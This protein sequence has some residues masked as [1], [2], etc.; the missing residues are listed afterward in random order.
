[1]LVLVSVLY[2]RDVW[3]SLPV[4]TEQNAGRPEG[5]RM[6]YRVV[7]EEEQQTQLRSIVG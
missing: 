6:K 7:L 2:E 3:S 5:Y 4:D 1:M